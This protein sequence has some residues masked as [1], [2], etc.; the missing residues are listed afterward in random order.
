V[1]V[2][3]DVHGV[4]DPEDER[5]TVISVCTRRQT[6]QRER[7]GDAQVCQSQQ[8]EAAHCA[9]NIGDG[10]GDTWRA[11]QD[12][13]LKPRCLL[14]SVDVLVGRCNAPLTAWI[15][16]NIGARI[17]SGSAGPALLALTAAVVDQSRKDRCPLDEGQTRGDAGNRC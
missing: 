1:Y 2:A 15:S 4:D 9:V 17:C 10:E 16:G 5:G 14:T 13:Y 7:V 11:A 6:W 12:S 8:H 3:G